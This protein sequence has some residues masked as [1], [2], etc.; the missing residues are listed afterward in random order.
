MYLLADR[1]DEDAGQVKS[2]YD[3]ESINQWKREVVLKILQNDP[4]VQP[5]Q[6]AQETGISDD[7]VCKVIDE[8]E[9]MEFDVSENDTDDSS[10]DEMP[11]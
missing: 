11:F 6:I 8:V 1:L 4:N 3:P 10:D 7:F 2:G 5:W 9:C